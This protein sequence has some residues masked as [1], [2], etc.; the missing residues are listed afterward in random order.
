VV[1]QPEHLDK[2]VDTVG[3][4]FAEGEPTSVY[5]GMSLPGNWEIIVHA[6]VRNPHGDGAAFRRRP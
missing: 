5:N 4:A 2:V 1:M 6:V 3:S